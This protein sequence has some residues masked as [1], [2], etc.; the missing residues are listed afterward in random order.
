[1]GP[2]EHTTSLP[3]AIC[4]LGQVGEVAVIAWKQWPGTLQGTSLQGV[5]CCGTGLGAQREG[6]ILEALTVGCGRASTIQH[7]GFPA[8]TLVPGV[9][10][11]APPPAVGKQ[12]QPTPEARRLPLGF[13][14]L[15]SPGLAPHT[16]FPSSR[17]T[18][19]ARLH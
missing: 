19:L 15:F 11:C 14:Q 9:S 17:N 18:P 7:R 5:L 12:S 8:F 4:I 13:L 6:Q 2:R 16:L 3:S 10:R 1:M